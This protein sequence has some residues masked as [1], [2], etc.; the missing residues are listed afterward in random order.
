MIRF[1]RPIDFLLGRESDAFWNL[2]SSVLLLSLPFV[3]QQVQLNFVPSIPL[4]SS[5]IS[6]FMFLMFSSIAAGA[7]GIARTA[8]R[9]FSDV[10]TYTAVA[11]FITSISISLYLLIPP[12]PLSFFLLLS[13]ILLSFFMIF[14]AIR[15]L[16]PVRNMALS[17]PRMISSAFIAIPLKRARGTRREQGSEE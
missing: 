11:S 3:L 8:V 13:M 17:I 10:E 1:L 2:L 9:M 7:V 16:E 4:I 12:S 5:I 6:N 15:R 14:E